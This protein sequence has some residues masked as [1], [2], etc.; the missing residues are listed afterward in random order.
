VGRTRH[1]LAPL[2]DP[3][4]VAVIGASEAPGKYGHILLRTLIQQ[5][6]RGA[7]HAVNPRGGSLL[8]LPFLRSLE[9]VQGTLDVALV[10]RPAEEC[11]GIVRELARRGV[12]FAIVYA[13][14]FAETGPEGEEL[15]RTLV[16]AAR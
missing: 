2:L 6:Y 9:E 5:G 3:E 12:P 8:G 13:A 7:I 11:P 1:P 4:G 10:V 14:G 15:Q 16:L